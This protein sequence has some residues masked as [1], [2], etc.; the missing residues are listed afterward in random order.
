[1]YTYIYPNISSK[2]TPR[3]RRTNNPEVVEAIPSTTSRR[4]PRRLDFCVFCATVAWNLVELNPSTRSSF[5]PRRDFVGQSHKK[6]VELNPSTTSSFPPRRDFVGQ[7]L[8]KRKKQIVEG[9]AS[10]SSRGTPRR[11]RGFLFD[12]ILCPQNDSGSTVA[13][14]DTGKLPKSI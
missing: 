8:K 6:L 10:T 13:L 2:H 9:N 11:L 7:S 14:T 12:E 1:M 5:P 3:S 4:S